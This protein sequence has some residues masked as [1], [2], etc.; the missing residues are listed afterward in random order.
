M[1]EVIEN[2]MKVRDSMLFGNLAVRRFFQ[3]CLDFHIIE[4][5]TV[6]LFTH[7]PHVAPFCSFRHDH[8]RMTTQHF[9]T[10]FLV[11]KNRNVNN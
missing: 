7:Y 9:R 1:T 6:V 2:A 4:A 10:K 5:Y 8:V 11:L 3:L